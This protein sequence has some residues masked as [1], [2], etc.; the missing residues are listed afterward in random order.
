MFNNHSINLSIFE[1]HFMNQTLILI[2]ILI[3]PPFFILLYCIILSFPLILRLIDPFISIQIQG[4]I[5]IESGHVSILNSNQ[6]FSALVIHSLNSTS[7]PLPIKW[8][9]N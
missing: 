6:I 9:P 7:L 5:F 8:T 3:Q 2:Q 4:A 1:C